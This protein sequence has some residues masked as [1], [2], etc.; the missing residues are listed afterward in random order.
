MFSLRSGGELEWIG[1]RWN[2]DGE[3]L[4]NLKGEILVLFKDRNMKG[5][6]W[7]VDGEGNIMWNN[8]LVVSRRWL[9]K[10]LENIRVMEC[11]QGKLSGEMKSPKDN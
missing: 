9:M 7:N 5:G 3:I 10:F 1:G 11:L 4:V 8:S 2:V 6:R